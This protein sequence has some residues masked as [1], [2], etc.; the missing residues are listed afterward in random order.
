MIEYENLAA[1]NRT[2]FNEYKNVFN[3]T[4]VSGQYI[5]G[6]QVKLFEERF[7][8]YC[9]IQYCSGVANGLDA[10]TLALHH[11]KFPPGSEVIVPSNTYIATI[12][13]IVQNGLI[14]VLVEPDEATYNINPSKIEDAINHKTCCIMVVHLYGKLC[15][16]NEIKI[17]SQKYSLIIIEDCAQAHG[18]HYKNKKAGSWGNIG[19]FSFYPTKNLGALADAG[20]IT[21]NDVNIFNSINEL[22]NYGSSVKYKNDRIGFNSRLDEIQAAFLLIKLNYL[23]KVTEHKRK[24]AAIYLQNLNTDYI[25]PLV[26]DDYYDVYHIFNIRHPKRDELRQ[27]LLNNN[28]KTEIHYPIPPH[29]QRAMQDIIPQT[30]FPISEEIH[31]TTLSLPI[32]FFHTEDDICKVIEVMNLF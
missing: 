17:L 5:L 2:F 27:Y 16:M 32:S 23:D 31:A 1:S 3:K 21:T 22:R 30:G 18:A 24:L 11:Y 4:L 7:A 8:E 6:K 29:K 9:G 12:L 25:L 15:H 20:A 28:I 26:E 13:A 19:A 10:L 14:P